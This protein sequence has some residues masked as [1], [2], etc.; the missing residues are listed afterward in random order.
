M[1]LA[2]LLAG[3]YTETPKALL[4]FLSPHEFL[5]QIQKFAANE[6]RKQKALCI[7]LGIG[8]E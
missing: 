8:E 4:K 3:P 5:V 6:S 1:Q 2:H 7:E